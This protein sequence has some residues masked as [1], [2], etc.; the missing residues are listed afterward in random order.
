MFSISYTPIDYGKEKEGKL[1]IYTDEMLWSYHIKGTFPLYQ[2]PVME[3][4]KKQISD[5][6]SYKAKEL[7]KTRRSLKINY[8]I[9]NLKL[10][11][12]SVT[13]STNF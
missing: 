4:V 13:Q 2:K 8:L 12:A 5:K 1:L 6:L 7:R 11:G 3:N 9:K 10:K